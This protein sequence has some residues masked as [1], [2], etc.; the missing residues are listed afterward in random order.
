MDFVNCPRV[1]PGPC[2]DPNNPGNPDGPAQS[3]TFYMEGTRNGVNLDYVC[4]DGDNVAG[5]DSSL[6][7]SLGAVL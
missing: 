5:Q 1:R 7:A 4:T 2:E 3:L 6:K